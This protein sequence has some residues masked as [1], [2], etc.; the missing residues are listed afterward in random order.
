MPEQEH[1]ASLCPECLNLIPARCEVEGAEA[2]QVK[3]CP[4]HGTF[5]TL[6]W[7]GPPDFATW[8]RP[9]LPAKLAF[10]GSQVERG[11]PFDCGL[12]P[13]HRQ[14]TCTAILEVAKGC[15][16]HCPVCYAD[17]PAQAG[18]EPDLALIENWYGAVLQ[19]AAGCNIQLSGGEPTIRDDLPEIVAMGRKAG[20]A[21]IQVNTNG[22]R[23]GR[24]RQYV[25]ALTEAGLSSIFLQFDAVSDEVYRRLRGGPMLEQKLRAIEACAQNGI[26]VVLV[27]TIVP[28]LNQD[29]VGPILE[30]AMARTPVVRAVHFQPMSRFGRYPG[31]LSNNGRFTLPD[32]MRTIEEQS[33]GLFPAA[34]FRPPGC[35]NALCSF[36]G[37][38][39]IH[40]GGKVQALSQGHDPCCCPPPEPAEQGALRT[41]A[42]VSRNWAA[43]G[44]PE[45]VGALEP[46]PVQTGQPIPLDEFITLARKRTL[47]VSAMAFQDVW[48]LDLERVRDCCI[49]VVAQDGRLVP[50]CLYNLTSAAGKTLYRP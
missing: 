44:Q 43:P 5:R 38:F 37:N 40:D 41:I 3:T 46:R 20:F 14:R 24:D 36:Q 39:L 30:L 13:E 15:D 45:Q 48:N 49:H 33:G 9:K 10:Y 7:R 12:C 16:L 11:C 18:P 32:L 19:A 34:S 27:P 23:L 47:S 28:G 1:G 29:Q 42:R 21:F 4:E 35:E 31:G 25:D 8:R 17:A 2:Y 6:I 26:G 50:F 22:L